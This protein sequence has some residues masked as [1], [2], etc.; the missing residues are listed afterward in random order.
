MIHYETLIDGT[1]FGMVRQC[2]RT[3][4]SA[5]TDLLFVAREDLLPV[6]AQLLDPQTERSAEWR[7]LRWEVLLRGGQVF[8]K[9]HTHGYGLDVEAVP[10][11]AFCRVLYL[12]P[13]YLVHLP[14]WR[15]LPK[16]AAPQA[17]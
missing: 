1:R 16:V 2:L 4:R 10:E 6:I 12:P 3:A 7:R 9:A 17:Q 11:D 5:I 14:A 8:P 13:V 15:R